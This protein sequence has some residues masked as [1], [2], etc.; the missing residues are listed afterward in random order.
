[1]RT[2]TNAILAALLFATMA[3]GCVSVHKNEKKG[4]PMESTH[5]TTTIDHY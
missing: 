5:S 1:M 3:A 2:T 4:E